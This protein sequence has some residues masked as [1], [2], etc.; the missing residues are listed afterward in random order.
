MAA[1]ATLITEGWSQPLNTSLSG[2][3]AWSAGPMLTDHP[4]YPASAFWHPAARNNTEAG[5]TAVR[6]T[7]GTGKVEQ[8]A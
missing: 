8:L 3:L 1:I 6:A 4:K 2:R 7:P 5:V